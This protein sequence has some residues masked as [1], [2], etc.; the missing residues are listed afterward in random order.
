[1]LEVFTRQAGSSLPTRKGWGA[2]R[3][4]FENPAD[5]NTLTLEF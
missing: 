1:L 4:A 2:P 3:H 5:R